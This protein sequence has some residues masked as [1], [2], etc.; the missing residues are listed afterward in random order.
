MHLGASGDRQRLSVRARLQAS[1]LF[2]RCIS[3]FAWEDESVRGRRLLDCNTSGTIQADKIVYD[4]TM[5]ALAWVQNGTITLL[6]VPTCLPCHGRT[7]VDALVSSL[8]IGIQTFCATSFR[9]NENKLA[10]FNGLSSRI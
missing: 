10:L 4:R 5:T 6:T 3:H 7:K 2:G 8:F 9:F 1:V